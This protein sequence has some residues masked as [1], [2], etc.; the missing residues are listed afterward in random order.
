MVDAARTVL[1]VTPDLALNVGN[2]YA[3]GL[4]VL[5]GDKFYAAARMGLD[6]RVLTLYYRNGY[7]GYEFD[8]EGNPVPIPQR[9]PEDFTGRLKV[10]D[11]FRVRLRGEEVPVQALELKEGGARAILFNPTSPEWAAK[12]ADRV[13]IEDSQEEGFLKYV[14]LARASDAY[15]RRNVGLDG[16]DFID[17]QEA[18]TALLPLSLRVPGKYRLVIHTA[19]PWGHPSFPREYFASECGYAFADE[20]MTLTELGLSLARQAFAVS[21]KH[22]DVLA[23][24]F[25]HHMEKISYITNGVNL[26]RWMHADIKAMYENHGLSVDRF[27]AARNGLRRS[28][29]SLLGRYKDVDLGRRMVVVWARR[30]VPY[31]RPGLVARLASELRDLPI[32]FVLGGKAHPKDGIGL[33]TMKLFMRL[34]R[35]LD[36]VVYIPNYGMEEARVLLSGGDLLLFTPF[37]GWEACGTSYMKAGINGVPSISSRDGGALEMIVD[38]VNGWFFGDDLRN[39]LNYGGEEARG[40]DE[41]EY[42]QLRDLVVRV[43][44]MYSGDPVS[45]YRVG[46]SAL[47]GFAARASMERVMREYY[48]ELLGIVA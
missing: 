34:H 28:L 3:G 20:R 41:A 33:E 45:F 43:H 16:I 30:L 31:K 25:P 1:S 4:G 14:L 11:E 22:M 26:E 2:T 19:G 35:E 37:S 9:Q 36:N 38:G 47:R 40:I 15:I 44:R 18:Y 29:E 39:L 10:A 6:Y 5:E 42:A 48:P 12:L 13:Y 32:T 24:V 27:L 7:V 17:L 21:A 23:K 8:A 46:L